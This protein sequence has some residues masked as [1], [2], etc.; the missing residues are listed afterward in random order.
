[1]Y[2]W[3]TYWI[4]RGLL[5]SDMKVTARGIIENFFH[6]VKTLGYV[7]NANRVYYIGR[8]QPPLLTRMVND[9]Y[10]ATNDEQF[11]INSLEVIEIPT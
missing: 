11:L 9:Y 5:H 10:E 6:L 2:Y 3:D 7:P 1:M 8:S 4:L